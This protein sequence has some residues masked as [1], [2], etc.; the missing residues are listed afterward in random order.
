MP[1][2][3]KQPSKTEKKSQTTRILESVELLLAL[4]EEQFDVLNSEGHQEVLEQLAQLDDKICQ[5]ESSNPL[6]ETPNS[7][8]DLE[9]RLSQMESSLS[10]KFDAFAKAAKSKES[11]QPGFEK[12]QSNIVEQ[13]EAK[14]IG[15]LDQHFEQFEA[16]QSKLAKSDSKTGRCSESDAAALAQIEKLQASQASL[17]EQLELV[18]AQIEDMGVGSGPN[19]QDDLTGVVKTVEQAVNE[20]LSRQSEQFSTILKERPAAN[21]Q[22]IDHSEL[23]DQ[24]TEQVE[25]KVVEIA[26]ELENKLHDRLE[27]VSKQLT[28]IETSQAFK[29]ES[30]GAFDGISKLTRGDVAEELQSN[31]KTMND[32]LVEQFKNIIAEQIP[33]GDTFA[34]N[35]NM[36]AENRSSEP[37][38]APSD[39]EE[40][41]SHWHRQKRAMLEKYGID[42]DYRPLEDTAAAKPAKPE[43]TPELD[44][45]VSAAVKLEEL[46]ETIEKISPEDNEA[47]EKL[48]KDLNSKL[49]DAEVELSINRAKLS[50]QR[51]ELEQ[52]QAEL[53][54]RAADLEARLA[55][56]SN[57]QG[58]KRESFMSR[59]TRHLG[60]GK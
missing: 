36:N 16:N 5:L 56:H 42:P 40:S 7:S 27:N 8:N 53:E 57:D 38:L 45:S 23:I 46:H 12:L 3:T 43:P 55:S 10:E 49:R 51:A 9:S 33:A 34:G 13:I 4:Q 18:S 22:S 31:L 24:L 37:E 39:D 41:V 29:A 60:R 50:Q 11:T 21:G 52:K 17:A 30:N 25:T 26:K 20:Q 59:F 19:G 6:L 32:E 58:Q 28:K 1:A 48:K 35:L 44:S 14:L 15:R 2:S 54:Q 47:I